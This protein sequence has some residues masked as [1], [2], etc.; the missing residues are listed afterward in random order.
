MS[1]IIIFGLSLYEIVLYF[2]IYAFIGWCGEVIYNAS[3][4]G[5]F[6]N[7]G[8]LNGPICPIYGV[9]AV[10]LLLCL[11]SFTD[12][13]IILFI[14]SFILLTILEYFTGF[15]LDKIFHTK[16]WD[17]TSMPFNINGYVCLKYSLIWATGGVI[18]TNLIHPAISFFTSLLPVTIGYILISLF[19]ALFI[20]DLTVTVMSILRLNKYLI[21]FSVLSEKL[22]LSSDGIGTKLSEDTIELK[23][24]D[25]NLVNKKISLV[26]KR[27]LKAFPN[28]CV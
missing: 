23:E 26:H 17:Y 21:K 8:L 3:A 1:S 11:R 27:I 5:K 16:W 15:L 4:T 7:C 13:L 12:N 24:K 22:K 6:I 10:F 14:G 25:N 19:S 20:T 9:G 18:L 28:R 2:F